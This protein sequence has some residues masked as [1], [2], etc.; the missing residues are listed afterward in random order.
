MIVKN[1]RLFLEKQGEQIRDFKVNPRSFSALPELEVHFLHS[2][3]AW[4][5]PKLFLET[6]DI[7]DSGSLNLLIYVFICY[8]L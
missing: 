4:S 7:T 1:V 6:R 2:L 5:A 3:F 8:Q